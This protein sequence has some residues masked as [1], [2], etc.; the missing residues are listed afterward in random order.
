MSQDRP[1]ADE[2]TDAPRIPRFTSVLEAALFFVGMGV[3]VVPLAPFLAGGANGKPGPRPLIR[4]TTDGPLRSES[5][6]RE[7]W[8]SRPNAQLAI[9]L[10]QLP[11]GGW[12]NAGDT[13]VRKRPPGGSSLPRQ[14]VSEGDAPGYRE[15][16]KSS[17][18]HDLFITREPVAAHPDGARSRVWT[19]LGGYYDLLGSG[20]CIVAPSR[21]EN[22]ERPYEPIAGEAV[23]VY[24]SAR[25]AL[26]AQAAWLPDEYAAAVSRATTVSGLASSVATPRDTRV[27]AALDA[28]EKDPK[29]R[30]LF[31][32]GF[33]RPAGGVDRSQ[34]EFR[35]VTF[36]KRAGFDKESVLAVVLQAP[37]TKTPERGSEYFERE[38]WNRVEAR[39][40]QSKA[41]ES[42]VDLELRPAGAHLPW[43]PQVLAEARSMDYSRAKAAIRRIV[44]FPNETDYDAL[45]LHLAQTYI[46]DRLDKTWHLGFRGPPTSGKST[47]TRIWAY[48]ADDSFLVG[49]ATFAAVADAKRRGR[50]LA[51][52]E[53]DVTLRRRD[54]GD[55]VRTILRQGTDRDQPYLK[56]E[57]RKGPDG[58]TEHAAVP[59]PTFGP[60]AF[61]YCEDSKD[62][63]LGS[64]TDCIDLHR[65]SDPK[66]ERRRAK[67]YKR[68]LA[69][70][71]AWLELEAERA[72]ERF[73]R[74]SLLAY[75][76]SEEFETAADRLTG[77]LPRTH[78]IG[79]L[80]LVIGHVMGWDAEEA[81][82]AR[83]GG[84][85]DG[86]VDDDAEEVRASLLTLLDNKV[87]WD[88]DQALWV[89][90]TVRIAEAVNAGK[91]ARDTKV[92]PNSIPGLLRALGLTRLGRVNQT[93]DR[94]HAVRVS[95]S[96]QE[97]LLRGSLH[98]PG[99]PGLGG[100]QRSLR[101]DDYESPV[102]P[103]E[104]GLG[105]GLGR[106]T[107]E[108][109][110][111][112]PVSPPSPVDWGGCAQQRWEDDG[113]TP[114]GAS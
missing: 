41:S 27:R 18:T 23:P 107:S 60:C 65:R 28:V 75:E 48:L 106:P 5:E 33:V 110:A 37:H 56:T 50:G 69:S 82:Q 91:V 99:L 70:V 67:Y 92:H 44:V 84:I 109:R 35:L 102:S 16:T 10:G 100:L 111:E 20:L 108:T 81:I 15:S 104:G 22:G 85:E 29:A 93:T 114:G 83:L 7:F 61:N 55:L 62:P 77:E 68:H 57:E 78:E 66:A 113:G 103:G 12:L 58:R 73:D 9:A 34:T 2:G 47:A 52:D 95:T 74:D 17:G 3:G 80:M 54:V 39:V 46:L 105:G 13:D 53:V 6:V 31:H 32:E 24:P 87:G 14:L 71:K 97:M 1:S 42:G 40:T 86:A 51:L 101:D 76:E 79:E 59:I 64:R 89:L 49:V 112:S 30:S 63:A 25:E 94:R 72:R 98:G 4:W 38:V 90:P 8:R 21:F 26:A 88:A 96:D 45:L 36:L 19:G 43:S 11:A